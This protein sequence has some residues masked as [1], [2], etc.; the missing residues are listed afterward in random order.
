[1]Q[2]KSTLL[3]TAIVLAISVGSAQAADQFTTLAGVPAQ[4]LTVAESAAVVGNAFTV[5]LDALPDQAAPVTG[6][7]GKAPFTGGVGWNFNNGRCGFNV[8]L[9]NPA[10]TPDAPPN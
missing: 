2:F 8:C 3:G 5:S 7:R 10:P 1:M 6:T 4:P 9:G